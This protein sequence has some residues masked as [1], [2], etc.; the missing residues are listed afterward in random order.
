MKR[1]CVVAAI[2]GLACPLPAQAGP[3]VRYRCSDGSRIVAAFDNR[4]TGSATLTFGRG[5]PPLTLPQ[6][7]SADGGR[8]TDQSTEFWIKGRGATLTRGGNT[9][10]CKTR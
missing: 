5:V 8:Y 9:V 7:M 6:A 10:T 4:G 1:L 2:V 3:S